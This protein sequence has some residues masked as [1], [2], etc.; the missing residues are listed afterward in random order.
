LGTNIGEVLTV[1]VAMLLWRNSPLLSM[2]L[3]W[4]NLVTDS[5]PAIALGMERPDKNVMSRKPRPKKEGIFANG[6]GV[7][8]GLQGIMF[9]GLTLV[10]FWLGW[11]FTGG[12]AGGRTMAFIVLSLTQVIHAFNMRSGRSL[13]SSN[14]FG[15]KYLTGAAAISAALI[16]L[17]ALVP[18]VAA[19]F[20]LVS[21]APWM[22]AA[23]VGLAA[24]PVFVLEIAKAFGLIKL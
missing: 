15:N 22:Y 14:P 21:L 23:A 13:F 8:I 12:I 24:A 6:I 19:V 2:Q 7:Q 5:L 17:V 18:P 20:G 1:F 9:A 16:A 10:G 3:L 11:S 4:I